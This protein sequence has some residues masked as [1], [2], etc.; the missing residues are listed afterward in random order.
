MESI[1]EDLKGIR[2]PM[3]VMTDKGTV[4]SLPDAIGRILEEHVKS[5]SEVRVAETA[6]QELVTVSIAKEE[7]VSPLA[8]MAIADFGYM[9]GCP[10][11]G[12]SLQMSE[13]CMSCKACGYSRCM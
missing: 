7:A 1:I 6:P 2:G 4:L 3:P 8:K 12:A 10:D 5:K 9:P 11:C 13:G